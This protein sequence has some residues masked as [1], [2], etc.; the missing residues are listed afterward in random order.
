MSTR[1]PAQVKR[2]AVTSAEG[3]RP[4]RAGLV[5]VVTDGVGAELGVSAAGTPPAGLALVGAAEEGERRARQ[6]LQVDPRRAVLDV[7]DVQLDPV[8]P[9]QGGAAV[10]LR[11]AGDPG[12]DLQPS[13]L[14][15]VV[16]LHLVAQRRAGP[17][18]AHVAANDVPELG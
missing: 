2:T 11:P 12:L 14:A 10:D 1:C 16:A 6:D 17:D 18:H 5:D 3:S 7:P 4:L 9:G 8:R 15:L 13:A